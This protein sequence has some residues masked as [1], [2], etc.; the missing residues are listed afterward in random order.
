MPLLQVLNKIT[1]CRNSCHKLNNAVLL[2]LSD[3][4]ISPVGFPTEDVTSACL[5]TEI[6]KASTPISPH[7]FP[8]MWNKDKSIVNDQ[9]KNMEDIL[10]MANHF[11]S[12]FSLIAYE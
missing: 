3:S 9:E 12:E 2:T 8:G 4:L 1:Y 5:C 7:L 11:L 10:N 6:R